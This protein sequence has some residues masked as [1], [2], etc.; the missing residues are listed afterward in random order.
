MG[1]SV[2]RFRMDS[3]LLQFSHK[4]TKL[5][6]SSWILRIDYPTA[7]SK[8]ILQ[9]WRRNVWSNRLGYKRMNEPKSSHRIAW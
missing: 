8:E 4:K 9:T 3:G 2:E 5:T 6:L 1:E 7:K